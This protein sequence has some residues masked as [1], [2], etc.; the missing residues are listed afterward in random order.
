LTPFKKWANILATVNIIVLFTI[1]IVTISL[2]GFLTILTIKWYYFLILFSS[3]SIYLRRVEIAT[4]L[5]II[6]CLIQGV[7]FFTLMGI[8]MAFNLPK[9]NFWETLVNFPFFALEFFSFLVFCVIA[10]GLLIFEYRR[11]NP[12]KPQNIFS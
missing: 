7:V 4:V 3:L 5:Q 10:G 12:R 11:Y 9:T 2:F 8:G 6:G 1:W